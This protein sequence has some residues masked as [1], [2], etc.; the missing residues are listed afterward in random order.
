M[1]IEDRQQL[2]EEAIEIVRFSDI[3][4]GYGEYES[5]FDLGDKIPETE[6][7]PLKEKAVA[8]LESLKKEQVEFSPKLSV[9]PLTQEDY[10]IDG[11]PLLAEIKKKLCT[12]QKR[13]EGVARLTRKGFHGKLPNN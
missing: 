3:D 13:G 2:L 8:L 12:G 10:P 11:E 1:N 5:R 4:L 9:Y 7:D 6:V